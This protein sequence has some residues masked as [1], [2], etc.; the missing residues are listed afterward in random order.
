[1]VRPRHRLRDLLGERMREHGAQVWLVNT[2][3]TGGPYGTGH[4]HHLANTRAM[5]EAILT[6]ALDGAET[7]PEPIF[8]L[9]VP[10]SVPNVPSE[11]LDTRS[12]WADT[13]AFDAQATALQ[14]MFAENFEAFADSVPESVR[15]AGP[16]LESA[17]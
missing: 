15:Q 1:M 4:R 13:A 3:W 2:G 16:R 9:A 17:A 14:R 11:I 5:I 6:G 7:T 12:T 8:G 10:T